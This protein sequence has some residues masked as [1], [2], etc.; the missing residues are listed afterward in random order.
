[1]QEQDPNSKMQPRWKKSMKWVEVDD[2]ERDS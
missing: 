1:M 2:D